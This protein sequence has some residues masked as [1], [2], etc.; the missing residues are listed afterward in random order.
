M[1]PR[2]W[3][4]VTKYVRPYIVVKVFL[5]PNPPLH[6]T[7]R[8]RATPYGNVQHRAPCRAGFDVKE[9]YSQF[10]PPDTTCVASASGGVNRI[11]N[12]TCWDSRRLSPIQFSPSDVT[13]L[14]RRV[15]SCRAVWIGYEVIL[16]HRCISMN[17]RST[18]IRRHHHVTRLLLLLLQR[19]LHLAVVL[20]PDCVPPTDALTTAGGDL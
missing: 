12:L 20:R 2:M 13:Q 3:R 17:L 1:R 19:G 10:T 14:D 7:A 8:H 18:E 11:I 9:P 6:G 4:C 16:P 5:T 15:A